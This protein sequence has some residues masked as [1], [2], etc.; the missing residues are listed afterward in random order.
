MT[1][2]GAL[3]LCF[4]VDDIHCTASDVV[5]YKIGIWNQSE[6]IHSHPLFIYINPSLLTQAS[7]NST[8]MQ[9]TVIL[10]EEK[11]FLNSKTILEKNIMR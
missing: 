7:V 10:C 11:K 9:N 1:L 3:V 8:Q 5:S 4:H 6:T 2:R